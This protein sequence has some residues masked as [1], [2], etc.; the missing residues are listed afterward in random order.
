[1]SVEIVTGF[2]AAGDPTN[3]G[4]GVLLGGDEP[5]I[6]VNWCPAWGEPWQHDAHGPTQVRIFECQTRAMQIATVIK[7]ALIKAKADGRL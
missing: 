4:I 3:W 5:E 7:E 6:A 1:M 2:E